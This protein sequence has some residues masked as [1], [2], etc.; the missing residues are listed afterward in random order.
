MKVLS[1]QLQRSAP[2]CHRVAIGCIL[3]LIQHVLTTSRSSSIIRNLNVY[4]LIKWPFS[5]NSISCSR[6]LLQCTSYAGF[7]TLKSTQDA[8]WI[9]SKGDIKFQELRTSYIQDVRQRERPSNGITLVEA[10]LDSS[11]WVYACTHYTLHTLHYTANTENESYM[12]GSQ[13]VPGLVI[14][15]C[16][17][18]K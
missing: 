18:A 8:R 1:I 4:V 15:N 16:C 7:K 5:Q 12:I 13:K 9:Y 6:V 17:G 14:L 11:A 10:A 2:S 3:T